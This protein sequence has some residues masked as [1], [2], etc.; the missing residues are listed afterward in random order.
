MATGIYVMSEIQGTER[1]ESTNPGVGPLTGI[2]AKGQLRYDSLRLLLADSCHRVIAPAL[3]HRKALLRFGYS[4][5]RERYFGARNKMKD[6]GISRR[7]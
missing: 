5:H 2:A 7:L 6:K 4:A 3:R 1:G